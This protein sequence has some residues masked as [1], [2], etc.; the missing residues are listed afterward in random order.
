[1]RRLLLP[2]LAAALAAAAPAAKGP[3]KAWLAFP[4]GSR[5]KAEVVDTPASRQ[6]GL[7]F[8]DALPK[9]YGMLFVF[10]SEGPLQFWMKNTFI[11]LDIVFIDKR[12][13]VTAV[14]EKV[15]A[16]TPDTD[17]ADIPR[18]GGLALYVLELPAGTAKKRGVKVGARLKFK[19]AIPEY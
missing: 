6:K 15:P 12:K 3:K 5:I 2:L 4:D 16:T 11:P 10:A 13:K 18:V 1:M 14:H 17:E 8:R 7:M 9:D 19:A